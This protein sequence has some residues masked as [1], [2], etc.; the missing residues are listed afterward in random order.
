MAKQKKKKVHKKVNQKPKRKK[1]RSSRKKTTRKV[2]EQHTLEKTTSKHHEFTAARLSTWKSH[3]SALLTLVK[4]SP[5]ISFSPIEAFKYA[6]LGVPFTLPAY[7]LFLHSCS[8]TSSEDLPL[9][10]IGGN[11]A[12]AATSRAFISIF[13]PKTQAGRFGRFL[14]SMIDSKESD[15]EVLSKFMNIFDIEAGS[16][17]AIF[18]GIYVAV[19]SGVDTLRAETSVFGGMLCLHGT[20]M[21]SFHLALAM[22]KDYMTFQ[23]MKQ[24]GYSTCRAWGYLAMTT[25]MVVGG[26]DYIRRMCGGGR[27]AYVAR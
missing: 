16:P 14:S 21:R 2:M 15:D 6:K 22:Y 19:I 17:T 7:K 23:K 20:H 3:V 1:K 26:P 25:F 9:P 11:T 18:L 27:E 10:V 5:T 12:C 24:I 8:F 4:M 13:T